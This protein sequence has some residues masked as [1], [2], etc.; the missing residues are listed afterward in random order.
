MLNL[1]REARRA[2]RRLRRSPGFTLI[3]L[4]CLALG[5]GA[6]STVFGVINGLFLRPLPGI[7]AAD[8]LVAIEASPSSYPNFRDI[9]DAATSFTGVAAFRDQLMSL[10]TEG[11]PQQ[12]LGMAV[13]G[14]YFR[15]LGTMPAM[16]R[17][18]LSTDDG[19]QAEPVAVLSHRLWRTRFGA[20][21]GVVG[22][23]VRLNGSPVS[24][25]GVAPEGF[26]GVFRGF[27]FDVWVPITAAAGMTAGLQIEA[28]D[29]G[30]LQLLGRLRAGDDREA[31]AAEIAAIAQ[32]LR[33]AYPDANRGLELSVQ[34]Y[35]GFDPDLR[36]GAM[37][38]VAVLLA[39]A[40]LVLL[41]ACS[42]VANMLMARGA[43][44]GRE[45]AVRLALG[46]RRPAI[47]ALVVG[48]GLLLASLAAVI[49]LGLGEWASRGLRTLV[50]AFPVPLALDIG[51]DARVIGFTLAIALLTGLAAAIV[52]AV[53]ASRADVAEALKAAG[54]SVA[55]RS[56]MG[57]VFVVGQVA[58]SA[59]LL[60]SAGLLL[61]TVRAATQA[62]PGFDLEAVK[63]APFIDV[64]SLGLGEG[65]AL[66]LYERL[67][68]RVGGLAGVE[69][70]SLVGNV[71]LSFT[72]ASTT[73]VGVEGIEPPPGRDGIE[74]DFTAVAPD[75]FA[76][77]GIPMRAGR[78][79]DSRDAA[80][81]PPV[82]VV[83]QTLARR[84]WPGEEAV[85]KTI[86]RGDRDLRVVGVVADSRFRA[87]DEVVRPFLYL[88]YTQNA[89]LRM[90]LAI[91]PAPGAVGL[92]AAVRGVW[93][94]VEPDLAPPR[95][96]PL[97]DFLALSLLPQRAA[98]GVG[99]VLGL[100]GLF[101]AAL[102]IFGVVSFSVSRRVREMGIRL[103]LGSDRGAIVRLVVGEGVVLALVGLAV[104]VPLA[105]A[106][107]GL[108]SGLLFG[109]S[110][111]DPV[112]YM[113]VGAILVAAAALGSGLPAWRAARVDPMATLREE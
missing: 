98:A 17:L 76:T 73:E 86:R 56:R 41:I 82:A 29:S 25:V 16:G 63:V 99:G 66:S 57:R 77:L 110:R 22:G 106:G 1:V 100:V 54:R 51:V 93:R 40:A 42:N 5:I 53:Q 3:A 18:I 84:F 101:L 4:A 31:A 14:D 102:G 23:T 91:R 38:L 30:R 49:G 62:D 111:S 96:Q 6:A 103:A 44:R 8:R 21:P 35:T 52:P 69:T 48:E 26:V 37:A 75:Y 109:V 50:A 92:G 36:G 95:V 71:P 80:G 7:A 28:R 64:A 61:Q 90:N 65:E 72:G 59:V 87:L 24:V 74:V 45:I 107:S 113:A 79:F 112:T 60:V 11:E 10:A 39:V 70:A 46:G 89:D 58:L 15:L 20:D 33:A 13:S 108:L 9:R 81:S 67:L 104:G 47:T 105:L 88:P 2:L 85:G 97:T 12:V 27:Q 34:S 78:D 55:G 68:E 94:E 32:R 43:S 83:N 19:Q